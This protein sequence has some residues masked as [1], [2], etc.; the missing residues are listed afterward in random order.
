MTFDK[1]SGALDIIIGNHLKNRP[2]LKV[3][4]AEDGDV[5]TAEIY[6]GLIRQM[7]H[8]LKRTRRALSSP[9]KAVMVP[10]ECAMII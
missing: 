10:G 5:D 6:E 3:V 1:T 8:D 4:G 7:N 9:R 2:G